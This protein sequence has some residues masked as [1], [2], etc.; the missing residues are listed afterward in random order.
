[1]FLNRGNG[2]CRQMR[3]VTFHIGPGH[4]KRIKTGWRDWASSVS[5]ESEDLSRIEIDNLA[6]SLVVLQAK[7]DRAE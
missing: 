1:M 5:F 4:V 6:Y 3:E 7:L 2:S